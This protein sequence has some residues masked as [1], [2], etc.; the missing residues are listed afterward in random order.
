MT[1][2]SVWYKGEKSL[3]I[4][5]MRREILVR[6]I[7]FPLTPGFSTEMLMLLLVSEPMLTFVHDFRIYKVVYFPN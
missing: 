1:T 3:I 7:S 6:W 5:Y 2:P 4:S